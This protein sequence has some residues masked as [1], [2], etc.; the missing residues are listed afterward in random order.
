[1]RTGAVDDIVSGLKRQLDESAVGGKGKHI[2]RGTMDAIHRMV[3]DPTF[4]RFVPV[5]MTNMMESG[6]KRRVASLGR[7]LDT[8]AFPGDKVI[9]ENIL[10]E[11]YE[12]HQMFWGLHV[13]TRAKKGGITKF[14]QDV[15]SKFLSGQARG[16][17]AAKLL[18]GVFFALTY[19]LNMAARFLNG[20]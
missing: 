11:V 12:E 13:G 4:K 14:N 6:Y 3:D 1:M 17:T 18:R 8:S 19:R 7:V 5:L 16:N 2:G 9:R 15:N 10:K 20:L